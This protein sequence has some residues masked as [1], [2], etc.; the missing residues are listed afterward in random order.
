M[1]QTNEVVRTLFA[2]FPIAE[3]GSDEQRRVFDS[4][5]SRFGKTPDAVAELKNLYKVKGFSDFAAV[6]MWI[7]ERAKK[8]PQLAAASAEDETLLLSTFRRALGDL[9]ALSA[10]AASAAQVIGENDERDFASRLERFS[11]VVQ[12]GIE[13]RGVQ[14]ESLLNECERMVSRS[15]DEEFKQFGSLMGDFLKYIAESEL[16]DDVRVINIVSNIAS[17]ISQWAVSPP[18]ARHGSMEEALGM[19][20]DFRTHFE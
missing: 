2:N 11:E 6:M 16:L 10:P 8:D 14:L 17:S 4:L 12:S 13:G 20:R 19:L 18:E 15:S 7:L 1:T 9:T 5:K 3:L